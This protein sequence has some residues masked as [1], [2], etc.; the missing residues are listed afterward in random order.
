[1]RRESVLRRAR[2]MAAAACVAA[3]PAR[4][5]A[6]QAGDTTRYDILVSGGSVIDGTGSARFAADVA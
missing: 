6:Q 1:M 3:L 4:V 2:V 5:I